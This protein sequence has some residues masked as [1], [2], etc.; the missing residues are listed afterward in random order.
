MDGLSSPGVELC[1]VWSSLPPLHPSTLLH[2]HPPV[3]IFSSIQLTS[4]IALWCSTSS[5]SK[6]NLLKP[7]TNVIFGPIGQKTTSITDHGPLSKSRSIFG[8]N[9]KSISQICIW[10]WL[11]T[12]WLEVVCMCVTVGTKTIKKAL[13]LTTQ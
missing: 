10:L 7:L 11:W 13:P 6:T 12:T 2:P 1:F 5:S 3:W 4:I 9:N 8:W